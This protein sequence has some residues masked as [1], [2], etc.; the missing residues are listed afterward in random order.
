M[1]SAED[2]TSNFTI[3][4]LEMFLSGPTGSIGNSKWYFFTSWVADLTS[5]CFGM[6]SK[7]FKN[8]AKKDQPQMG[9]DH[10]FEAV[11]VCNYLLENQTATELKPHV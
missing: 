4:S 11:Q 6:F 7:T 3:H 10:P 9:F 8:P 2:P 5:I 1:T